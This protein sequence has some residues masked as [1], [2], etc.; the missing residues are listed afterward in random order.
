MTAPES[1]PV[2]RPLLAI[3]G[4]VKRFGAQTALGGGPLSIG[5]VALA[6]ENGAGKS[7]LMAICSGAL[8]PDAGTLRWQGHAVRFRGSADAAASDP[9]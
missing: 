1:V 9:G 5:A 2:R 6:G 4:V 7:T 3:D 8:A